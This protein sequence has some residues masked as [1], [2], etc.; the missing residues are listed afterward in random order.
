MDWIWI[1]W[2]GYG[3]DSDSKFSYPNTSANYMKYHSKS[4]IKLGFLLHLRYIRFQGIADR[5]IDVGNEQLELNTAA[6]EG[7]LVKHFYRR[8]AGCS[9]TYRICAV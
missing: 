7:K 5:D 9:L 8:R 6:I 4:G 2:H 3:L 1:C